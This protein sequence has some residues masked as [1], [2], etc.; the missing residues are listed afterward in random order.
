[1]R[2]AQCSPYGIYTF[3]DNYFTHSYQRVARDIPYCG[4][5]VHQLGP[6]TVGGSQR[7]TQTTGFNGRDIVITTD[8]LVHGMKLS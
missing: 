1:M 7:E 3:S 5:V 4:W 8:K 2:C 6:R